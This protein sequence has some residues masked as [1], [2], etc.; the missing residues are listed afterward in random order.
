MILRIPPKLTISHAQY[1]GWSKYRYREMEKKKVIRQFVNR[2]WRFMD[3][4]RKGLTGDAAV[5]VVK[6]QE[7]HRRVS[8]QAMRALEAVSKS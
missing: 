4:Y 1:W 8:E 5:W 7:G 6:A 3:A 2:S